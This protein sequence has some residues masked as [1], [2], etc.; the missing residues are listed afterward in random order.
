MPGIENR[1]KAF[2]D[3]GLLLNSILDSSHVVSHDKNEISIALAELKNQI[4][5]AHHFNTWFTEENVRLMVNSIATSLSK[6]SLDQW[7]GMYRNKLELKNDPRKI[8][9]IMAGNIPMVGFHDFLCVLMS[10]N[11]V[12]AKLSSEDNKLLPALA[13]LLTAIEPRFGNRIEFVEDRLKDFDAVIATGSNNTSR[14]FDYYFGQYPNIIRK[15]RNGVAV[16]SGNES[17]AELAGLSDDIFQYFGKG[18][19]NVSKIFLPVSYPFDRL[20]SKLSERTDV[21]RISKYFNNYEYNKAIFLVNQVLHFD[22]GNMLMTES[23]QYSSPVSVVYYEF[24]DKLDTLKARLD[25]ERDSIQCVVSSLGGLDHSIAFG[26]T[27]KPNLWDYAD[28]VD[29]MNF[30]LSI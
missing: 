21:I 27:Q 6:E 2:A 18:C 28:G 4:E 3:L 29:T 25:A 10:G 17:N 11:K 13:N 14:Y 1:M 23:Q 12:K 19:R 16:L 30:L 5:N 9:V 20:L 22:T 8:G 26:Q 24:Y 7:V 15:N